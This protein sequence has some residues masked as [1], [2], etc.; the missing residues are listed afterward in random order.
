MVEDEPLL[1]SSI[2]KGLRRQSFAVDIAADGAAAIEAVDTNDYDVVLL[3]RDLPR[4]HGDDVCKHIVSRHPG[5]RTLMLTAS[6]DV[7]D[8][9]HGLTLGADDYLPKPFV[10]AELLARTHALARRSNPATPPVLTFDSITLDPQRLEVFRDNQYVS[11]TKKE[12]GVLHELMRDP[13]SVVSTE[14]LLE[15]VWDANT[16]PF[17]NVVRVTVMTLRRKLGD[18]P[19]VSTVTGIGYRLSDRD[20]S[21]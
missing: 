8:K 7:I 14:Q 21:P 16:D 4:I 18:P 1:A 11:L 19:V 20:G 10:F 9:V 17:T 5:T 12:F 6:G 2:A 13:G 3:D 15:S